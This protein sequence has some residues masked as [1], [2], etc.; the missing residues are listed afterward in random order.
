[1]L[2]LLSSRERLD[3]AQGNT[4][5]WRKAIKFLPD[6]FLAQ[7]D[8][9]SDWTTLMDLEY[10][11]LFKITK[12]EPYDP[13]LFAKLA[14]VICFR[15]YPSHRSDYEDSSLWKAWED[16]GAGGDVLVLAAWLRDQIQRT[17]A[18]HGKKKAEVSSIRLSDVQPA[19]RTD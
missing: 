18:R 11:T 4:H 8:P 7:I 12:D 6:S 13:A 14:S 9:A 19:T 15:A 16:E 10:N 2:G 17:M 3:D 5:G 1:M